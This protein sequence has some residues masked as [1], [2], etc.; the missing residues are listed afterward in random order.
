MN[1]ERHH[2]RVAKNEEI[3]GVLG[4]FKADS[5]KKLNQCEEN[6]KKIKKNQQVF[7]YVKA[8][9]FLFITSLTRLRS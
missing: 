2:Y 3:R 5:S 9:I 7:F 8:K 4:S 1:M 6:L